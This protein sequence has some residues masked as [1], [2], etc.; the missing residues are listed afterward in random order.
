MFLTG[1]YW[2]SPPAMAA[3]LACLKIMQREGTPATLQARGEA[4]MQGLVAAGKRHGYQLLPSGPPAVPFITF[5][6][7]PGMR[8]QQRFCAAVTRRGAV[9]HPHHNWF[10]SSAHTPEDIEATVRMADEA[11]AEMRDGG[12]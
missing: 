4:L 10:L 8:R 2:N 12:L 1:S 7:D 5:T 11:L 6:E 3:A 9:F